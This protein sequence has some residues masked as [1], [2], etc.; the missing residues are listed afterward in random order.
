MIHLVSY[1]GINMMR[2]LLIKGDEIWLINFRI[3]VGFRLRCTALM[4]ICCI[5]LK[6]YA[7]MNHS[8]M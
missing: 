8:I 1:C 2:M 7:F 6:K 5:S 3:I 4:I